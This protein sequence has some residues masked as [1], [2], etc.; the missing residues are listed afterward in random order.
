[1][2]Q[3]YPVQEVRFVRPVKGQ[4]KASQLS[5]LDGTG[6]SNSDSEE[7]NSPSTLTLLTEICRKD[8]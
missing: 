4:Y 1:M 7:V 8:L 5:E 3:T 6:T 2:I